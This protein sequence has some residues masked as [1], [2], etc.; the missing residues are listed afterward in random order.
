MRPMTQNKGLGISIT[1]RLK[2][3]LT[4]DLP[5]QQETRQ[6]IKDN[7]SIGDTAATTFANQIVAQNCRIPQAFLPKTSYL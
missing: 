6:I 1:S 4:T 5:R 3:G 7:M 2:Q